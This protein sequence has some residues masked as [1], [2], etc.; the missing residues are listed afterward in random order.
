MRP[1]HLLALALHLGL[2]L[3]ASPSE[4]R[5]DQYTAT[6]EPVR[7]RRQ[8]VPFV[9]DPGAYDSAT[10]PDPAALVTRA[11]ASWEAMPNTPRL[12]V[13]PGSVGPLGYDA[14]RGRANTSGLRVFRTGFPQ[15]FEGSPLAVTLLTRNRLTGEVLDADIVVDAEHHRFAHLG[16]AGMLGVAG[17][18]NDWQN[19]V[20][21]ELGHALGLVEDAATP[22]AAMYPTSRPGEVSK[23]SLSDEDRLSVQ[24]AYATPSEPSELDMQ[25]GCGGAHVGPGRVGRGN[26]L[27][28]L[29][30]AILGLAAWRTRL[31]RRGAVVLA[32]G[33]LVAAGAWAQTTPRNVAMAH[34]LQT[35]SWMDGG[36][37]MTRAVVQTPQGMTVL[38]RPGGAVGELEQ[39]VFDA[40]DAH[41]LVEGATVPLEALHLP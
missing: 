35:R 24:E 25:P 30:V 14:S 18:P 13:R 36:L 2:V 40:H 39:Q 11:A 16:P 10:L 5:S 8:T 31:A 28:F 20:T 32:C 7:W 12:Q 3:Q 19:T 38:V 29:A 23:R 22:N 6:R 21:H 26:E 41:A 17:A 37:I 33:L 1:L 34:V 9:I 15:R 4:A 27:A